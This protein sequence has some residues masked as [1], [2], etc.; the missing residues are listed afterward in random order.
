MVPQIGRGGGQ[1]RGEKITL[2]EG[3][4]KKSPPDTSSTQKGGKKKEREKSHAAKE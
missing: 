2:G 4:R 1:K 3:K